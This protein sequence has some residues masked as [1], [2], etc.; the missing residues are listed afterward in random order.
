MIAVIDNY[1]SF[2]YNLVQYLGE[3]GAELCVYRNDQLSLSE[4]GKLAPSHI[5]I[6]PGPGRP[7]DG[8]V[9]ND[10]IRHF[11]QRVPIL[12]VC[13]GHQLLAHWLGGRVERA[14]Q[15]EVGWLEVTVN[16][17]GLADPLL[18]GINQRYYAFLWHW[19]QVTELPPGTVHLA[20]SEQC[21][22][23]AF[24]YG[25]LPVW[26]VQSNPQYDAALAESVLLGAP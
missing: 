9:S 2:T 11:H 3:L 4:L 20:S 26:G 25:D 21:P 22:I 14:P 6:S 24:R 16:R 1:D 8:G 5:V 17:D 10:V 13:L 18:E 19:D 15:F 7:E 12:G 23:Q